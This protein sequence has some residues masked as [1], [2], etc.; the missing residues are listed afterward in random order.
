M[1]KL[2]FINGEPIIKTHPRDFGEIRATRM[3]C[4]WKAKGETIRAFLALYWSARSNK[5]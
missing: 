3:Y 1:N 2:E 5:N 4:K